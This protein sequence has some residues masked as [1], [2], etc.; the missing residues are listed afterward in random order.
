MSIEKE[1]FKGI[2]SSIEN[3][4][5]LLN[6]FYFYLVEKFEDDVDKII[7]FLIKEMDDLIELNLGLE[8]VLMDSAN[9]AKKKYRAG[10]ITIEDLM[11]IAYENGTERNNL[12]QEIS[13][14]EKFKKFLESLMKV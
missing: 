5:V 9:K 11:T 2:F 12:S 6:I 14:C 3:Q 7:N 8:G 13:Q 10:D 1:L 4:E